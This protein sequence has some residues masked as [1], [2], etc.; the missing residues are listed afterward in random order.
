MSNL[1]HYRKNSEGLTFFTGKKPEVKSSLGIQ[2][3][4]AVQLK[5][6]F[7]RC[8]DLLNNPDGYEEIRIIINA[9]LQKAQLIAGWKMHNEF[10]EPEKKVLVNEMVKILQKP[11]FIAI[12]SGHLKQVLEL[13]LQ[14][15]FDTEHNKSFAINARTLRTWIL[16]YKENTLDKA[17]TEQ[18]QWLADEELRKERMMRDESF[19]RSRI[20]NYRIF[21]ERFIT[22]SG[23][24]SDQDLLVLF[25]VVTWHREFKKTGAYDYITRDEVKKMFDQAAIRFKVTSKTDR[26]MAKAEKFCREK[27]LCKHIRKLFS[28]KVDIHKYMGDLMYKKVEEVP[29]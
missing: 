13:G 4:M 7:P 6:D 17:V 5:Y 22:L 1:E 29:F 10:S 25:N 16:A 21:V 18:N 2:Q 27:I 23:S 15:E 11:D 19:Q 24:E 28:E 9:F 20:E 14:G 26:N 8:S 3:K 12:T